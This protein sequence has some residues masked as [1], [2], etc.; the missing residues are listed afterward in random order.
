MFELVLVLVFMSPI[1]QSEQVRFTYPEPFEAYNLCVDHMNSE[2]QRLMDLGLDIDG[3][4]IK[5]VAI[6]GG[7]L[8]TK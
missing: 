3:S 8:E 2:V 6:H 7:C 5:P 1:G 4:T